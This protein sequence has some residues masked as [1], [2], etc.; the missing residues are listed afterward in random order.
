MIEET[1]EYTILR[2][3]ALKYNRIKS[4]SLFKK[5]LNSFDFNYSIIE[6]KEFMDLLLRNTFKESISKKMKHC[7]DIIFNDTKYEKIYAKEDKEQNFSDN[8][9]APIGNVL[10]YYK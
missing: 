9:I 1:K 2:I 4:I 6:T 3:N 7:I 10:Q 8:W 5:E